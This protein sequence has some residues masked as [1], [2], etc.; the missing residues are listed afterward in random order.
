MDLR[1][2]TFRTFEPH[3]HE[4]FSFE[5]V[6]GSIS[7]E[8]VEVE[9]VRGARLPRGLREPFSLIFRGPSTP[10]LGQD[11]YRVEHPVLGSFEVFVVPV[12]SR[13]EKRHYQVAFG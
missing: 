4:T 9:P 12:V 3:L 5:T 13:S 7:L 10:I 2:V 6:E 1:N 11:T 8:L